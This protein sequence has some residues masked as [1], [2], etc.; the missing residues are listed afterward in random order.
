VLVATVRAGERGGGAAARDGFGVVPLGA[1]RVLASVGHTSMMKCT[2]GAP[3]V[4]LLAALGCMAEVVAVGVLRVRNG[5]NSFLDFE[6]AP[7][8]EEGWYKDGNVIGVNS[9]YHPW[10]SFG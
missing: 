9:N 5:R 1:S 2:I 6:P 8:E 7:G 4:S 10:L 3:G